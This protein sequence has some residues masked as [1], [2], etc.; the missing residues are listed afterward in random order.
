MKKAL[1]RP[2]NAVVALTVCCS[3]LALVGALRAAD[4]PSFTGHWNFNQD[5]SDDSQQK[6]HDAQQSS[7]RGGNG[8]GGYPGG[9]GGYPGGGGGGYP[10]GGGGYP[11]GGYP[12]G[13]YP[14]GGMGG[15]GRGGIGLPGGGGMGRHGG[16]GG[17]SVSSQTWN[18]ISTDPKYLRIDQR[19]DQFVVVDDTEHSRTFYPDGKKHED[20]DE[21][22]KKLTTKAE[23]SGGTLTA[24]TKLGHSKITETYRRSEDGKQLV[25]VSRLDDS[26]LSGPVSIRRVYDLSSAA[27]K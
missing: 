12:G 9:G 2:S 3:M 4:Q 27:P 18:L 14:G 11:G 8:G 17:S 26:S 23:W 25:V 6:V 20:K 1:G 16:R 13:G 5:Q 22:G 7:T 21:N 24:E 15:I 19:S 10:G